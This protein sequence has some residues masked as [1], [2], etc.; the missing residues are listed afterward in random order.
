MYRSFIIKGGGEGMNVQVYATVGRS[1][2]QGMGNE[3]MKNKIAIKTLYNKPAAACDL[4]RRN[5]SFVY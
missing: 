5:D 3:R 2:I 1:D 4:K